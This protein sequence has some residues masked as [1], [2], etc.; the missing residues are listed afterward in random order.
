MF[1]DNKSS[2]GADSMHITRRTA[3]MSVYG[4]VFD[5]Q[6]HEISCVTV[7]KNIKKTHHWFNLVLD[8]Q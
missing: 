2:F 7:K 6:N 5:L 4:K 3:V 8:H 1:A